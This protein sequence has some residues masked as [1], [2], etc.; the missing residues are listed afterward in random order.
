MTEIFIFKGV[1]KKYKHISKIVKLTQNFTLNKKYT[2]SKIDTEFEQTPLLNKS[3]I[4]TNDLNEDIFFQS[5]S[6]VAECFIA[7]T[8][9]RKQKIEQIKNIKDAK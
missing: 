6:L 5:T 3:Y 8:I 1:P 2:A 7:L 9:E 4:V